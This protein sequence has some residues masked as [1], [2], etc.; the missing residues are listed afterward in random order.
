M[1]NN[2]IHNRKKPGSRAQAM[3]EFAIV[4]PILFLMLLGII[5]VGR[6]IF[7]VYSGDQCQPGSS[8]VR[9]GHWV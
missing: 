8:T 7:L 3:V 6:M 5:E 1:L 2:L 4:A 9:I